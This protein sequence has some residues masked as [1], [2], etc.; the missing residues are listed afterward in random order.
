[1]W[2]EKILQKGNDFSG[3]IK[4]VP[5]AL[6]KK[7]VTDW[8]QSI[9]LV[10]GNDGDTLADQTCSHFPN[11]LDDVVASRDQCTAVWVFRHDIRIETLGSWSTFVEAGP[12]L[13]Q[14]LIHMQEENRIVSIGV[15]RLYER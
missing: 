12:R 3:R 7:A 15:V 6:M 11:W 2:L 9:V 8:F 13:L 1:M 14:E 10:P 4:Y 5:Y